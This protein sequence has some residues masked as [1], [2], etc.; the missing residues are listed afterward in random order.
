MFSSFFYLSLGFFSSRLSVPLTGR[1]TTSVVVDDVNFVLFKQSNLVIAKKIS[2]T[3]QVYVCVTVCV[4][5][6]QY[7]D[8]EWSV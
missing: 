8:M 6:I 7:R 3:G 4:C 5:E 1:N 2:Y